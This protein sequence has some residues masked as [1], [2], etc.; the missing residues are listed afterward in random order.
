MKDVDNSVNDL[1]VSMNRLSKYKRPNEKSTLT[2][3]AN[4]I[5]LVTILMETIGFVSSLYCFGHKE[6]DEQSLQLDDEWE[7]T[8]RS[9]PPFEEKRIVDLISSERFLLEVQENST[10]SF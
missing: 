5:L 7:R 2:C 6:S 4:N 1:M 8:R 9:L 3:I 10:M